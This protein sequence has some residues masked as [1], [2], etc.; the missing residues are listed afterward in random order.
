MTE[1]QWLWAVNVVQPSLIRTES[2]EVTYNLHIMLR[3]ELEQAML[4]GDLAT[5]DLPAVWNARMK[6]YLGVVPPNDAQGCLQDIHWCHGA[7]GYFPTY[8]LGNLYAAQFYEQATKDIP[9]LEQGFET[10]DFSGL[11]GWLREK[12]HRHGCRY[13]A[14]DLVKR[15]T[16]KPLE[17]RPLLE[18]LKRKAAMYGV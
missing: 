9:S 11:L 17:A 6:D 7:V 5:K 3:F 10:G 2:D 12:I 18:H 15:V 8:T 16:G 13:L 14:R 1:E 4:T